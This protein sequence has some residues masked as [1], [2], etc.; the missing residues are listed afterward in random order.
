MPLLNKQV[1]EIIDDRKS[2]MIEKIKNAIVTLIHHNKEM[3]AVEF[4]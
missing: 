2:R 3:M 4:V 1:F